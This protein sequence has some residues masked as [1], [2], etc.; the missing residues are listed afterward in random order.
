M[1]VF[2]FFA[3]LR[4]IERIGGGLLRVDAKKSGKTTR[5]GDCRIQNHLSVC[6]L[7]AVGGKICAGGRRLRMVVLRALAEVREAR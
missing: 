7:P 3:I 2:T 4:A 1:Q 6:T 5:E